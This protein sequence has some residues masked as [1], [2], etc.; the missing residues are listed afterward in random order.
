[1]TKH[2]SV[3]GR[4]GDQQPDG[5][6][7]STSPHAVGPTVTLAIVGPSTSHTPAS[8]KFAPE[9]LTTTTTTHG[10]ARNSLHPSR[11][12]ASIPVRPAP[13]GAAS[14]RRRRV[15]HT[16]ATAKLA[17]SSAI[18]QPPPNATTVIPAAVGPRT[19]VALREVASVSRR[20]LAS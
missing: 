14:G 15:M 17:A 13:D 12:L 10:N 6:A 9:K 1:M 20:R 2:R 3:Q 7:L 8:T 16:A 4:S 19:L 5:P 18:A 11:R